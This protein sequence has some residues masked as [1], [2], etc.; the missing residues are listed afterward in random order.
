MKLR[1]W[2]FQV[3][4]ALGNLKSTVSMDDSHV[5]SAGLRFE[6]MPFDTGR[7]TFDALPNGPKLKW[8]DI[9]EIDVSGDGVTYSRAYRGEAR[10]VGVPG[11]RGSATHE[12]MSLSVTFSETE[13]PELKLGSM[14]AGAQVRAVISA[15]VM[16]SEWENAIYY[17]V[18]NIPDVGVPAPELKVTNYQ[19]LSAYLTEI[20]GY[21]NKYRAEQGLQP[22]VYGVDYFG[23]FHWRPASAVTTDLRGRSDVVSRGT[24][25]GEIQ[26]ENPCT[27]VRWFL[28]PFPAL[29]GVI[30]A[31]QHPA[32]ATL[33][34]RTVRQS[35]NALE[36]WKGVTWMIDEPDKPYTWGNLTEAERTALQAGTASI[37]VTYDPVTGAWDDRRFSI[38][39]SDPWVYARF[40][41][42]VL[43]PNV[44]L[45]MGIQRYDA[46][47]VP[48]EA[49]R[50]LSGKF[51]VFIQGW[52]DGH[53]AGTGVYSFI[54]AVRFPA[55]FTDPVQV[56]FTRAGYY[57]PDVDVLQ[58]LAY[59][60]YRLPESLVGTVEVAS[61]D[62]VVPGYATVTGPDGITQTRPVTIEYIISAGAY[63][64]TVYKF[65][66]SDPAEFRAV[67]D[68]LS[69]RAAQSTADAL[70]VGR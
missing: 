6:V 27:K 12:I 57:A 9:L 37:T 31:T 68:L 14:D 42:E 41:G 49:P 46:N 5:R 61:F 23:R 24:Q 38:T 40:T 19:L 35:L 10:R 53:L 50:P 30:V 3:R 34:R 70:S 56:R 32:A 26:C 18:G 33:R 1:T 22:I 11:S 63:G 4:D 45:D 25:W 58:R 51:D 20:T 39:A 54:S 65:G 60:Y 17:E 44:T 64:H 29:K 69:I 8:G 7:C 43:T 52:P 2:R 48:D 67:R 28:K 13:L 15:L 16:T 59:A 55:G 36:A 21:V 62:A 47:S 66:E